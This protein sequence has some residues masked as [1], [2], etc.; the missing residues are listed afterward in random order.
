[1]SIDPESPIMQK[2]AKR[3]RLRSRRQYLLIDPEKLADLVRRSVDERYEGKLA[4]AVKDIGGY[5]SVA[6]LSR[7]RRGLVRRKLESKT[8]AGLWRLVSLGRLAEL[9]DCLLSPDAHELLLEY[10]EWIVTTL[11]RFM[12][13][14]GWQELTR[15]LAGVGIL[16]SA[17]AQIAD[18]RD[19]PGRAQIGRMAR[20][21]R[22]AIDHLGPLASNELVLRRA[23]LAWTRVIEPLLVRPSVGLPDWQHMA[24]SDLQGFADAGVY[25]ELLLLRGPG[26]IESAKSSARDPTNRAGLVAVSSFQETP[27]TTRGLLDASI[28]LYRREKSSQLKRRGGAP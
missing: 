2:R 20:L 8:V 6:E 23:L 5:P 14:N 26:P 1:M 17:R 7:I 9:D 10:R 25:R 13:R 19:S 3:S 11:Q 18:Q 12:G 28:E 4:K 21:V 24:D 22:A 27:K 16:A 15:R